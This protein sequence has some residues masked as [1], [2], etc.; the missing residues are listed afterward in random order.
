MLS[1][2]V[3]HAAAFVWDGDSKSNG[4]GSGDHSGEEKDHGHDDAKATGTP[5][6]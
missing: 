3:W 5:W 4:A 1:R 2:E 6:R